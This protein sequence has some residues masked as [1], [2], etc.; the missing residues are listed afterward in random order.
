MPDGGDLIDD[1]KGGKVE[2]TGNLGFKNVNNGTNIKVNT[3]LSAKKD[4]KCLEVGFGAKVIL[5]Y[6]VKIKIGIEK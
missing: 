5:G 6:S 2:L 3:N 4:F 1:Y